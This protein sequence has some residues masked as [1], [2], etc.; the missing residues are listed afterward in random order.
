MDVTTVKTG[1]GSI[2]W[3]EEQAEPFILCFRCGICCT[4]Y[5][6]NLSL[7]EGRRIADGLELAW[8]EFLDTY[9]D[10]WPGVKNF[11][12]RQRNGAC[13]F[14]E[15]IEGS[16]VTRCVIHDFRP[17]A[18]AEWVPSLYRKECQQG[19]TKYWGLRVKPS[20]QLNGSRQKVREF[21]ALLELLAT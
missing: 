21:R 19:L 5:Q 12:L 1:Y 20:G 10:S 17:S 15:Q 8:N 16:I 18:C 14:L 9:L 3:S 4:G 13:V 7:A 11:L 2:L 6:V